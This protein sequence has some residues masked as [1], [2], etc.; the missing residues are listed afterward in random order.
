M[1]PF[2]GRVLYFLGCKWDL[3][4]KISDPEK[5]FRIRRRT[6]GSDQIQIRFHITDNKCL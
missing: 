3:V 2:Y 1:F 6:P 4:R 5:N